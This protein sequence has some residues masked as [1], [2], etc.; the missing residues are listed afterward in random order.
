MNEKE[1][2]RTGLLSGG[3]PVRDYMRSERRSLHVIHEEPGYLWFQTIDQGSQG[4][5]VTDHVWSGDY[6]VQY[7]PGKYPA[8]SEPEHSWKLVTNGIPQDKI[9]WLW[10]PTW[11]K[12]HLG[13]VDQYE[14]E[15]ARVHVR[16]PDKSERSY[17]SVAS[18]WWAPVNPPSS[19]WSHRENMREEVDDDNPQC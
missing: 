3:S 13:I 7:A 19:E 11:N 15:R 1:I 8:S 5:I 14:P 10:R 2:V 17:E 9:V 18:L 4:R 16:W 6:Y 12:P